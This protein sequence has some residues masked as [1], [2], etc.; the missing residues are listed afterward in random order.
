MLI[1]LLTLIRKNA[2][3]QL[4]HSNHRI[5]STAI[6]IIPAALTALS[7]DLNGR[8]NIWI[9]IRIPVLIAL[10]LVIFFRPKGRTPFVAHICF[11]IIFSYYAVQCMYPYADRYLQYDINKCIDLF[12][13]FSG[14][15]LYSAYRA[16]EFIASS[17]HFSLAYKYWEFPYLPLA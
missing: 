1:R 14:R 6:F 9:Y 12:S 3:G 16:S 15:H 2:L 4:S 10:T 7:F 11:Y 17:D 5:L 13:P 8:T